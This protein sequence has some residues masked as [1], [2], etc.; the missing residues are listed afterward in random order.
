MANVQDSLNTAMQIEGAIGVALVD[1]TSGLALGTAGGG[2]NFN[3]EMAAAGNTQVVRAKMGVIKNLSLPTQIEDI[4]ITLGSQYHLIR[5]C[6][7]SPKL[8]IY[9]ALVREV[10]NLAMAR[11]K[12]AEIEANLEL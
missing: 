6:V 1:W 9:I 7:K 3:L 10:S 8:F 2:N 12:L 5:M 11:Y 4:L